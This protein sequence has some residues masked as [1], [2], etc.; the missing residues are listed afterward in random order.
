MSTATRRIFTSLSVLSV[1]LTLG[2]IFGNS[3]LPQ[4]ESAELSG[5]VLSFLQRIFGTESAFAKFLSTYV[6]K[7]AH[8]TEFGLLAL[9]A[10]LFTRVRQ[11]PLHKS[12]FFLLP[13]GFLVAAT[14]E[15][16]QIFTSR[17]ASFV[18]VLIDF[19]GFLT[20]TLL[21]CLTVIIYR[22]RKDKKENKNATV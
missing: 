22:K 20:V 1:L 2:F 10:F 5:D 12:V 9:E 6:R 7:L 11:L 14:D 16:L 19:C 4:E 21:T 18:D 8:F 13:F 15:T 3:C 17:G